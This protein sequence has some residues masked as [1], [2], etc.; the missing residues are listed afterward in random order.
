MVNII[1][2]GNL[3]AGKTLAG[4]YFSLDLCRIQYKL[5][6]TDYSLFSNLS[7]NIP[8]SYNVNYSKISSYDDIND[9]MKNGVVLFDEMWKWCD[10]RLSGSNQNRFLSSW[11]IITRKRK[12]DLITT[13]QDEKQLDKRIR[14]IM[15]LLGYPLQ[16]HYDPVLSEKVGRDTFKTTEV[17]LYRVNPSKFYPTII[18][19][20][21]YPLF[22]LYDTTEEPQ[23]LGVT[24]EELVEKVIKKIQNDR[25]F[26][27][28]CNTKGKQ[29]DYL[30]LLFPDLK[31]R[32]IR[33][34]LTALEYEN[35]I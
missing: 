9:E 30:S 32:D 11:S 17:E 23:E 8:E 14:R 5:G 19:F 29:N 12:L 24:L 13:E 16:K 7:L 28:A 31:K 3:G 35:I 20:S 25:F 15:N 21:N 10:A 26:F 27:E 4:L 22:P 18:K 1:L 34:V 6:N 2:A 33:L